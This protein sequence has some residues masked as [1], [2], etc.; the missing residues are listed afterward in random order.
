MSNMEF[1][2]YVHSY[3]GEFIR[4]ADQ[5]AAFILVAATTLLG[6][7]ASRASTDWKF[8]VQVVGMILA[9]LSA[10]LAVLSV[11]PR[12]HRI[13]TG[14]VG[15][16]GIRESKDPANYCDSISK[17]ADSGLREIANHSYSIASILRTKYRLLSAAIWTF[18]LAGGA[19]VLLLLVNS[20]TRGRT[21]ISQES[22]CTVI[23][24]LQGLRFPPV[25]NPNLVELQYLMTNRSGQSYELPATVRVLRK[26]QDGILHSNVH[27]LGFQADRF[28]PT[29]YSVEFSVGLELGNILDHP[30]KKRLIWKNSLRKRNL[31]L[32]STTPIIVSWSCLFIDECQCRPLLRQRATR[33][34]SFR[35]PSPENEAIHLVFLICAIPI[36]K[37]TD[38]HRSELSI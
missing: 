11:S 9:G 33:A 23:A 3:L 24:K 17:L 38:K 29:G 21:A 28:F 25:Y 26:P 7:I 1:A 36:R 10:A 22:S 37:V 27:N 8:W 19:A 30:T 35:M 31:I 14:L 2:K 4:A 18:A 32:F 12:Q 34:D 6:W 13:N 20:H 5:K 15:W 16:G